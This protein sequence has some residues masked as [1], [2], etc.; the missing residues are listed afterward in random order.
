[1][2]GDRNERL[3]LRH[4]RGV[5]I[6][7][8]DDRE[9]EHTSLLKYYIV[10]LIT[11][12]ATYFS[13]IDDAQPWGG[14]SRRTGWSAQDMKQLEIR[15]FCLAS[16]FPEP[17]FKECTRVQVAVLSISAVSNCTIPAAL[18]SVN[19]VSGVGEVVWSMEIS[20]PEL[21]LTPRC[22]RLSLIER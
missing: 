21:K 16:A 12:F 7:E 6:D 2:D 4:E 9:R 1:V 11:H 18:F 13:L 5:E 10:K 14:T 20:N 17:I 8:A 3:E 22:G 19:K 15:F